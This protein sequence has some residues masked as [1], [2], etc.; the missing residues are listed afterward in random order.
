MLERIIF[1]VGKT[2]VLVTG[3][4]DPLHSGHLAYFKEAKKLG[5]TLVVG[6]N[7][8]SW[9]TRKKGKAF[10]PLSERVEIIK[11]LSV[12]D[13]VISFNDDDNSACNAI[14][15][16]MST[17]SD[18]IIFANGGD[19]TNT[20]IPEMK[21][22]GD[23]PSVEFA[24]GVG[25]EDKK[26]S[27]SWIL[28]EWRAPKIEREWGHYRELYQGEGFQVKELVISPNSKLSMQRH[29]YRSE[30]W[31]IVSGEAYVKTNKTLADNPFEGCSI[32]HL[33]P[34]NPVDIPAGVWHQGCNDTDKPAH[35]VEVWKGPTDKL[36][37]K[38]IERTEY[39]Y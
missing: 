30:T 23:H 18:K 6:V 17:S 34:N 2:T 22:Y 9:L 21:V 38:D 10:M 11:G 36:T 26:N 3:G 35:I 14:F 4:F 31:N 12:V 15:Q 39:R 19:R 16:T 20:N 25:G 13:K 7:S 24:F 27:S 37:E 33:H 28:K 5:E 32:W 1:L 29:K 8:D